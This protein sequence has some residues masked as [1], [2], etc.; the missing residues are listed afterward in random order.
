MDLI[1][2]IRAIRSWIPVLALMGACV[3]AV[4]CGGSDTPDL[5]DTNATAVMDYLEQVNYQESWEL[6]PGFGEMH[7]G[8]DPHG[9]LL[10]T[11]LN[12]VALDALNSKSGSMPD[13]AIIV[14]ENYTPEGVLDATTVMFK[15]AGY[16]PEHNDWFWSKVGADGSVQ[17]EGK[18]EGCQA[19]HG[20]V[21]DNDY[22]FTGSL[23]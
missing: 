17:K 12:P 18:V 5:P 15:K 4:S 22:V 19:C 10:T 14:K 11:Y 23:Q 13:G 9:T 16:N 1:M 7:R 6:W 20:D 3:G 21:R 2:P 8:G